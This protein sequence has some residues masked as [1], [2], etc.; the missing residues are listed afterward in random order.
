[1]FNIKIFN[2]R[3][4]LHKSLAA[5]ILFSL[6]VLIIN[7]VVVSWASSLPESDD[8]L[9]ILYRG[10][11]SVVFNANIAVHVLINALSTLLLGASNYAMQ[12]AIAPTRKDIDAAHS[13]RRW[14]EIGVPS[15]RN[16]LS[17]SFLRKSCW[18]ILLLSSLPLHLL[19]NSSVYSSQVAHEYLVTELDES[20]LR[21]G[22]STNL[23]G[24][25]EER[26]REDANI[27][28]SQSS[29]LVKDVFDLILAEASRWNNLTLEECASTYSAPLLTSHRTLVLVTNSTSSPS[30]S[31][32]VALPG[33][34]RTVGGKTW[35]C[36]QPSDVLSPDATTINGGTFNCNPEKAMFGTRDKD[37]L[38][39]PKHPMY[40]LAE[41]VVEDCKLEITT[42]FIIVICAANS[43]K[44]LAM[45]W[46]FF[47]IRD[48]S[49]NTLGDAIASFTNQ[50]DNHTVGFSHYDARQLKQIWTEQGQPHPPPWR[51]RRARR[52][53][54]ISLGTLVGRTVLFAAAVIATCILLGLAIREDAERGTLSS[55]FTAAAFT[56][57]NHFSVIGFETLANASV[58]SIILIVNTPQ[59]ALSLI[60]FFY[61]SLVTSSLQ[62]SEW[63]SFSLKRQ[64]L[65]VSSPLPGQLST[66]WLQ[67]PPHYAIPILTFSATMHW[68]ISQ[69][70]FL[71][72]VKFESFAGTPS[73]RFGGLGYGS[74]YGDHPGES[75]A[76]GY[77]TLSILL[78]LILGCVA[79]C[80][81]VFE[82]LRRLKGDMVVGSS[83]SV[84]IAAAC[85]DSDTASLARS[86]QRF[87]SKV[88]VATTTSA[89]VDAQ[90]DEV[91][92][93]QWGELC[94]PHDASPVRDEAHEISTKRLGF[95]TGMVRKPSP[96]T[97][98]GGL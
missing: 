12:L 88:T 36:D 79:I 15:L 78:C 83:S 48:P 43:S 68:L 41:P 32:E 7:I 93:L 60:Y 19:Y 17:V 70:I 76:A 94:S 42:A 14:L 50:P 6:L 33:K 58:A 46:L 37:K 91:E 24:L 25:N 1:M 18:A 26:I 13:R 4:L 64:Q 75:L 49:L 27:R 35:M 98:Y 90:V 30:S 74:M 81:L 2:D 9:P 56:N 69:A 95:S 39:I 20:F 3:L 73:L 21:D 16:L 89:E 44:I 59:V 34:F 80:A 97:L 71:S 62:A 54:A 51:Q 85:H 28:P 40:C 92:P 67:V 5:C 61:N 55:S 57:K 86:E 31:E 72:K 96:S 38:R 77:S 66:Y 52:Y 8:L 23:T 63:N 11:C 53:Q 82:G 87:G 29:R 10:S 45:V 65:R 22:T 84:V 47:H